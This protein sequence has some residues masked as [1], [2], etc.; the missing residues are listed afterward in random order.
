MYEKTTLK[1]GDIDQTNFD[2]YTPLRMSQVP[3]RRESHRRRRTGGD[4][5]RARACERDL[6]CLGRPRP[7][8]ADHGGGGEGCDE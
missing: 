8:A 4:G 5:N 7:L 2:T 3:Q 6:Q 1:N